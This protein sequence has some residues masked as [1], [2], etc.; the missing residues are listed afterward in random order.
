ME[1]MMYYAKAAAYI[2]AALAIGIGTISP[3]LAQGNVAARACENIGK[4]PDSAESIRSTM[5]TATVLIETSA[6]YAFII[7]IGILVLGGR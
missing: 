1:D 6:I 4:Y 7:S 2:A 5:L 3:A